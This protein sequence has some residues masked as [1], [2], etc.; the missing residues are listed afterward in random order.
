M[1]S[2]KKFIIFVKFVEKLYEIGIIFIK[3]LKRSTKWFRKLEM[4]KLKKNIY[5]L[6]LILTFELT[7]AVN[8]IK[9]IVEVNSEI[10]TADIFLLI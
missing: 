5:V 3:I 2:H 8:Y 7:S 10:F 4:F 6:S 1:L 9:L